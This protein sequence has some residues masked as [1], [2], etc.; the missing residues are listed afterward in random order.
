MLS[1]P[2]PPLA[3]RLPSIDG[4][5][6]SPPRRPG[7]FARTFPSTAFYLRFAGIILH[8]SRL[9][10]RGVYDGPT[11]ARSSHAV[12]RALEGVGVDVEISGIDRLA[13]LS[14]PFL[15]V[16]NHMS[17]LETAVLPGVIQPIRPVT[18]VVKRALIDMPVFKYVMRSRDPIV[19]A[20]QNPR[21]DLK[22]MLAEGAERLGRGLSVVVFPQ[23]SRM[24]QFDANQFNSIGVKLAQRTGVPIVPLALQTDAWTLGRRIPDLG[25]IYP[26]RKVRFAFGEPMTVSGRGADE[27]RAIVDFID[28]NLRR[29]AEGDTAS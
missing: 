24:A 19:V 3:E 26:N 9:A 12:L 13:A 6:R 5:Y 27:N 29:W 16:G 10:K 7:W 18:F 4:V 1:H 14:N 28:G 25:L 21:D 11:W 15:V 2:A 20:Q 8:A 17:T 22:T 23:G